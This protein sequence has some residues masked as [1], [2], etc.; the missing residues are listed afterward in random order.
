VPSGR[1]L[2]ASSS[3]RVYLWLLLATV[4]WGGG[5]VAGKIA[6]QGVPTITLGV[7]RFG[8]AAAIL[9]AVYGSR[10]AHRRA[11]RW[12]NLSMLALL[13]ALGIFLNHIFYFIALG[14]APA[15]HAAII[16][17]TTSPIWTILLAGWLAGERTG[18]RQAAGIALC[19]AGVVL[20]VQPTSSQAAREVLI[21]DLLFGISGLAWGVYSYLSKVAM[22]RLD[23]ETIL[24]YAMAIGSLMLVPF[25]LFEQPW[26]ALRATPP[27]AWLGVL[28]MIVAGTLLAYV[29]WN[30]GIQRVGAGRTAVFTNL[31]PVFGVLIAWRAWGERLSIAQ[32]AGAALCLLGVWVCQQA[33][34]LG[35]APA[36]DPALA[37]DG[38]RWFS[39][40]PRA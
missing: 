4:F 19:I 35:T 13:G 34:T 18:R 15:S 21:G 7:L 29:W 17:P 23:P 32:L 14:Q 8:A 30:L 22:R 40:R 11:L 20:V 39:R 37:A 10:L 33:P 24:T 25:A 12:S 5:P 2:I 6:L 3:G 26:I 28:Y 16:A 31:V 36:L 1:T 27:S 9:V 38:P